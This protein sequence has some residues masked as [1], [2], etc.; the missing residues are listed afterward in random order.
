MAR[1][2]LEQIRIATPCD[3]DWD[4]MTGDDRA[5]FCG[6]CQKNVYNISDMTREEA[7]D[8]VTQRE[9]GHLCSVLPAS[10]RNRPDCRL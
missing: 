5:R 2:A 8:M 9:G 10:G 1:I 4:E 6:S 7:T 3:A